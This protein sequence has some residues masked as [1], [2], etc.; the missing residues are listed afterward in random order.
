MERNLFYSLMLVQVLFSCGSPTKDTSGITNTSVTPITTQNKLPKQ[1]ES[2]IDQKPMVVLENSLV[3]KQEEDI[4]T[5]KEVINLNDREN[6]STETQSTITSTNTEQNLLQEGLL[7]EE[8]V[9]N[10]E[11]V[12]EDSKNETIAQILHR[13]RPQGLNKVG[14]HIKK[15]DETENYTELANQL[16]APGLDKLINYEKSWRAIKGISELTSHKN[17]KVRE[18]AKELLEGVSK[19]S[20]TDITK[21]GI[22]T[23]ISLGAATSTSFTAK[24][25]ITGMTATVLGTAAAVATGAMIGLC[26]VGFAGIG[27]HYGYQAFKEFKYKKELEKY[28]N[29][30]VN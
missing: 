5:K 8:H 30:T 20:K 25:I 9:Q 13:K 23:M 16:K 21:Q 1:N 19:R 17:E 28:R 7:E 22:L 12:Q 18:A 26:A 11:V 15:L 3:S 2:I 29:A 10:E 24:T 6:N 4:Q 14:K 27:A